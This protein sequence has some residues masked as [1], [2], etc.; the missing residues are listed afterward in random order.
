MQWPVNHVSSSTLSQ[1]FK[2]APMDNAMPLRR[3]EPIFLPQPSLK[4]E[5]QVN[6]TQHGSSPSMYAKKGAPLGASDSRT[7][8]FCR[9]DNYNK[10]ESQ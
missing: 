9:W 2:M 8:L 5:S 3:N 1:L 10:E 6:A 7:L 4:S